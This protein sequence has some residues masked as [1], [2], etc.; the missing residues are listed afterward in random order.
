M[1]DRVEDGRDGD[2]KGDW[3]LQI[4]QFHYP[5]PHHHL[6]LYSSVKRSTLLSLQAL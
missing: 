4:D 5:H 3:N 2:I 1:D 6:H